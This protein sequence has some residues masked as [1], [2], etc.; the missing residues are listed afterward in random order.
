MPNTK[1]ADTLYEAAWPVDPMYDINLGELIAIAKS[2]AIAIQQIRDHRAVLVEKASPV[3]VTIFSDSN[4]ALTILNGKIPKESLW[5]MIHPIVRLIE[6]QTDIIASLGPTVRL[7]LRWIPGHGHDVW[8][9]Q[10]ADILSWTAQ[11]FQR[12]Y[13][14]E[15]DNFWNCYMESSTMHWLKGKLVFACERA[16]RLSSSLRRRLRCPHPRKLPAKQGIFLRAYLDGVLPTL[17]R[18]QLP[19]QGSDSQ[20]AVLTR[21]NGSVDI[22]LEVPVHV[23][24]RRRVFLNDGI[25]TFSLVLDD[26]TH[27][28]PGTDLVRY[29]RNG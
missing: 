5:I 25:N 12:S 7:Y 4:A 6:R 9:H 2:L 27:Q 8:P 15:Y 22:K 19:T 3:T 18:S 10:R 11:E 28:E 13:W 29:E 17:G 23:T 1:N 16:A 21:D 26:P 20:S 14:C 24:D